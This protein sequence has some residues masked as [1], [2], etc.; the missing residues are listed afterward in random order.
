MRPDWG[1]AALGLLGAL[2]VG[3][4]EL[5]AELPPARVAALAAKATPKIDAELPSLLDVYK[6]LHA[7]PELSNQEV[8]TAK[9]LAEWMRQAGFEVAQE[10]G[11]TGVVGVLKNGE[12]KRVMVRTDMDALPVTE[13]TGLD[14]ASR[15]QARNPEGQ[16]VGVMHACG[17]D[18]H[19]TCWLG[20]ARTLAEMRDQWSG[21]LVFIAQ[22]A[23]ELGT[24][25]RAMLA[26][27]LF[28]RFGKPDV[29]LALHCDS[30]A[31][32]G[33]IAHTEG[34]AMANVDSVDV[35]IKGKGGHGAI[36]HA[37]IDPIVVAARFILD[38]QTIVSREIDPLDS[39]VI[40]V[41]SIHGGTKHNI[42]PPEVNLQ[43][44]VR[45]FQDATREH[46]LSGIERVAN[47]A[48]AAAGAPAPEVVVRPEFT[49]AMYN[50]PELMRATVEAL[51]EVL[52][53][54]R[55]KP[56]APL[57][58][59]EDYSFFSRAGVPCAMLRLG[60]VEPERIE[61]FRA[62]KEILPS[63]H[64]DAYHPAPEPTIR[65]GVTALVASVLRIVGK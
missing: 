36:P 26:D 34:Y 8:R 30:F 64:S 33:E 18:M 9:K 49:P 11:G 12:G 59:G 38:V 61:R 29:G 25:A 63:L 41:G 65:T 32:A 35:T 57:M 50:D 47:A 4:G 31:A 7:N 1:R 5:R 3:A 43:L 53:A 54:E 17:H 37:T 58:G 39:A 15:V 51:K 27:G 45:S 13:N 44:T 28:D 20:A 42:V 2:W 14:Y 62:G 22:P 56:M 6:D 21:T 40:T 48:A 52:G 16:L 46:L 10:V 19:M 23:E 24:G 60:T 55:C